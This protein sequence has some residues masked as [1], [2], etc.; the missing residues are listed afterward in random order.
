MNNFKITYY[1]EVCC[2]ECN[3][4]IHNHLDYCPICK[5]DYAS[6]SAY[7][8][9]SFDDTGIYCEECGTYF[10]ILKIESMELTLETSK[11]VNEKN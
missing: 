4:I 5:K 9:I 2:D 6:T 8:E 10:S 7:H 1:A 11:E 3:S